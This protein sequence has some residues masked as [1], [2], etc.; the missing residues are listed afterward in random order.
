LAKSNA[1]KDLTYYSTGA[2]PDCAHH[3]RFPLF[4]LRKQAD[5]TERQKL[6]TEGLMLNPTLQYSTPNGA[7]VS[8]EALMEAITDHRPEAL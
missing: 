2:C 6:V 7:P 8:D 3:A 1:S 4:E 5:E